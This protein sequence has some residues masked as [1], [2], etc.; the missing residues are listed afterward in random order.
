[1]K[2]LLIG[3][4]LMIVFATA[5]T[6]LVLAATEQKTPQT[7]DKVVVTAGRIQE[8]SK[9][10]SAFMTVITR[11]E[12]EKYQQQDLG[13]LLRNYGFQVDAYSPAGVQSQIA[14]RGMRTSLLGDDT[15]GSI[16]VLVN[17]RRAGTDNISLIPLV[18]V[19]R[20]E[21]IRGPA[22]VQY[23][24]SAMGG[25]INII[26][27]RGAETKVA[28]EAGIGRWQNYRTMAEGS[29]SGYG[30]DISGGVAW[31]PQTGDY[32]TGHGMRYN[33]TDSNNNF[34]SNLNA[35]YTFQKEHRIGV[36]YQSVR[37]NAGS[38]GDL[39]WLTPN[40]YQK[41][42]NQS[43]DVTY[44]GGYTPVGLAWSGR[45]FTG[46]YRYN[47]S[48]DFGYS[49]NENKYQGAQ[50]QLSFIKGPFS[51]SGGLDWLQYDSHIEDQLFKNDNIEQK[52]LGGFLLAKVNLLDDMVI[53]SGGLR[54]D[55]YAV[56]FEG[57]EKSY[58]RTTP[59][60]GVAV[61]PLDWLTLRANYGQSF[62]I[63]QPVAVLGYRTAMN[64]YV[65]NPDLDPEKGSTWDVGAEIHRRSLS[66]G[67][68]YFQSVYKDKIVAENIP[69]SF[70]R[71]YVNL[72]GKSHIRGIEANASY[73]VGELFEW[74]FTVRP[75]AS[76]THLLKYD[77]PDDN[78]IQ[79]VTG[80]Q[81]AYGVNFNHPKWGL[82]V[83]LRFTYFG[84]QKVT[85][86]DWTSINYQGTKTIGGDTVADVYV[87]KVL[88][89][90]DGGKLSLKGEI[91]N[92]FNVKYE[93]IDYYP[94]AGRS[95]YLGLRYDY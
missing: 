41:R 13:A 31:A 62:R 74:D 85:E 64:T 58:Y 48:H 84:H 15:T 49:K 9:T 63:P 8:K 45:Y 60:V 30:F 92:I 65:G 25:A 53:L 71:R 94:M 52:D 51:L 19:E 7:M 66:F 50:G 61:N 47:F 78:T 22:S 90:G 43:L 76:L 37:S 55:A 72:R 59:S 81:M 91:R 20:V 68:T 77:D 86:F 4:C 56:D 39:T 21:V 5:T 29:A 88:F 95:F 1:M 28:A 2:R 87:S 70:D 27:R 18:N 69:S 75:Y 35:G 73:D 54:Y 34:A 6:T 42:R 44:E 14:I 46:E 89:G 80:T 57:N 23:G 36:N 24:T 67:L 93:T 82:N 40:D 10:V 16:L 32:K 11:E 79:Y 12:I 38:P 33:N 26:T 17:G 83:D 3:T